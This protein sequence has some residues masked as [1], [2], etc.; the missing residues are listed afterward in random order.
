[1]DEFV[2]VADGF[3]D[4]LLKL[5]TPALRD[6]LHPRVHLRALLPG[7]TL[8]HVG[9]DAVAADQVRQLARWHEIQVLHRNTWQFASRLGLDLRLQ[10][11]H[12]QDQ[13]QCEQRL[14]LDLDNELVHRI[15]VL[16]SGCH[17]IPAVNHSHPITTTRRQ[18]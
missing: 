12:G 13:W 14:Y 15:D 1:M 16:S 17:L 9:A 11:R 3:L 18:R 5:D 10:V 8:G 2:H 7:T 4:D 6:R